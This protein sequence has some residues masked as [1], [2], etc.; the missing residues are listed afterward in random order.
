M[1]GRHLTEE[2]E[3]KSGGVDF[4]AALHDREGRVATG[5]LGQNEAGPALGE[6]SDKRHAGVHTAGGEGGRRNARVQPGLQCA[7][8]RR[9]TDDS[10][11]SSAPAAPAEKK[12]GKEKRLQ[13]TSVDP[14]L[15]LCRKATSTVYTA[16]AS[17]ERTNE[18]VHI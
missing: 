17:D 18:C 15:L 5:Q 3:K 16:R 4:A 11:S 10:A 1:K 12:K 8:R 14:Q 6:R 7:R 13:T 9:P 2:Q